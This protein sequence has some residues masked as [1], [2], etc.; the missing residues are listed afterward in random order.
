MS[1]EFPVSDGSASD[2]IAFRFAPKLEDLNRIVG[3]GLLFTLPTA[4]LY[5]FWYTTSLRR[6]F[7][8]R[9]TLDGSV[10]EY[11]GTGRELFVGF[12]IAMLAL[13]PVNVGIF[14]LSL[15][16]PDA[17]IST[18]LSLAIAFLLVRT[19]SYLGRRY[20]MRR[21]AWRG[22]HFEQDGSALAY[23]LRAT[24][25]WGLVLVTIGLAFPFMRAALE[26]YR[27]GH[28]MFG[29]LRLRS[30][31]H[32]LSILRPW[33]FYWGGS[34]APLLIWTAAYTISNACKFSAFEVL[35]SGAKNEE[36]PALVDELVAYCPP[37]FFSVIS[38][39]TLV[40]GGSVI[41]AVLVFPY[42]RARELR[43]FVNAVVLGPVHLTSTLR[44]RNIYRPY[45]D[46][47]RECLRVSIVCNLLIS[48]LILILMNFS[49]MVPREVRLAVASVVLGGLYLYA[50]AAPVFAYVRVL[51]AGHWRAVAES[52]SVSD[53]DAFAAIVMARS[54]SAIDGGEGMAQ[55]FQTGSGLEI[56]F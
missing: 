46:Y 1:T 29:A 9:T 36:I 8:S 19:A 56:G 55:A 40:V 51:K 15:L 34:V 50:F 38:V 47:V 10:A 26:R 39:L 20:R 52:T 31:A 33:L 17:V 35:S 13:I 28:T 14:G 4:G 25:W 16:I 7:W 48:L 43:S 53:A 27:I 42:Y 44:A 24:V 32:G 11:S 6:F 30:T 22:I 12:V 45:L 5:R 18:L 3:K 37:S 2:A 54:P 21:T 23:G 49:G 41:F